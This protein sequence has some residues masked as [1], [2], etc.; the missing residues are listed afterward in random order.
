MVGYYRRFCRNFSTVIAQLTSL[1]SRKVAFS[2]TADCQHDFESAKAL[3]CTT[4]V[5]AAPNFHKP[6]KLEVDASSTGAG[7]VLL[8]EDDGGV[9]RPVCFFSKKFNPCQTRYSTLEKE[10]L[11][12]FSRLTVF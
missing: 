4:P 12:L 1:L 10:T 5:L 2:W 6:F 3:L 9:G 11:A 8:Q 7:A